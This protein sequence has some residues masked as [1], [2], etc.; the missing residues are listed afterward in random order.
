MRAS[1]VLCAV[2][3]AFSLYRLV[4]DKQKWYHA[5]LP[6]APVMA[7]ALGWVWYAR[8]IPMPAGGPIAAARVVDAQVYILDRETY[9]GRREEVTNPLECAELQRVLAGLRLRK[10]SGEEGF[11]RELHNR[12]GVVTISY[13]IG[14]TKERGNGGYSMTGVV[15]AGQIW[16]PLDGKRSPRLADGGSYLILDDGSLRA[17]ALRNKP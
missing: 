3:L 13:V 6:L 5:A 16:V 9:R 2:L 14:D 12:D 10:V 17:W 7:I 15:A 11:A 4:C 1:I 8:P